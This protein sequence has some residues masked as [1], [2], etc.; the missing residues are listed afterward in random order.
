MPDHE[1]DTRPSSISV[2]IPVYNTGAY[3]ENVVASLKDQADSHCELLFVDNGSSDN[4]QEILRKYPEIRLLNEPK[5]GSYAARNR[6]VLAA[7]GDIIAFTDSDCFPDQGWLDAIRKAFAQNQDAQVLLGSRNAPPEKHWLNLVSDYENKK[8]EMVFAS[9]DPNVYFGY[10]N[11][12]AVRRN[13]LHE[14]GPFVE[15]ARGADS[16]F[17]R[18]VSD[19]LGCKA[20]AYCPDMA[21]QHA[22]L[23]SIRV[24][25]SKIITYARSRKSYRHIETV[26]PLSQGERLNVFRA[27]VRNLPLRKS[28]QLFG[29]LA[30]GSLAWWY[31]G[32][33]VKQSDT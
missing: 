25:Y 13:V 26:R 3:L 33:G 6:G 15:R 31:G 28:L 2:V 18:R 9:S 11:N 30:W 12:M 21:V 8:A 32:L 20:V 1:A 22:E 24:Y 14:L 17:V 16:I 19:T 7:G 10:T 4:S 23:N 5:R 27:T 29:L